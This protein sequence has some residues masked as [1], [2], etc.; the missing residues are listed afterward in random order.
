MSRSNVPH[1]MS[2]LSVVYQML[3]IVIMA[4]SPSRF[5]ILTVGIKQHVMFVINI[6]IV[7]V[8][9]THFFLYF[10]ADQ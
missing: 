8:K 3:S 5:G 6:N 10:F 4:D 2:F 7:N 9:L 1:R